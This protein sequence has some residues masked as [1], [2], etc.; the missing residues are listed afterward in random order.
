MSYV[1]GRRMH[2]SATAGPRPSSL[3]H[4]GCLAT[5][6]RAGRARACSLPLRGLDMKVSGVLQDPSPN[7]TTITPPIAW[8]I[9]LTHDA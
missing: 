3:P 8:P 6:A 5:P 2:R 7:A 4:A 9:F 1:P